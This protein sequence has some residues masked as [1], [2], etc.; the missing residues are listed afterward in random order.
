MKTWLWFVS[1]RHE[2]SSY[3]HND[4]LIKKAI[5]RRTLGMLAMTECETRTNYIKTFTKSPFKCRNT[6]FS[7]RVREPIKKII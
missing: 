2:Y 6:L 3:S 1:A 7:Y 5:H 4:L